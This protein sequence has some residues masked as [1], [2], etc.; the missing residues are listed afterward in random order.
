VHRIEL[1]DRA[2]T[3]RGG[4]AEAAL[5]AMAERFAAQGH[6]LRRPLRALLEELQVPAFLETQ[7]DRHV[8]HLRGA[9]AG[10]AWFP[11]LLAREVAHAALADE[12]HPSHDP[13]LL[14]ASFAA[15]RE[16][17][18]ALP[19]LSLVAAAN[20]HVRDAYADDLAARVAPEE[21]QAFLEHVARAAAVL[22]G[23]DA[24]RAVEC[25][26]TAGT[27]ARRATPAPAE[28]QAALASLPDARRLADAFAGLHPDPEPAD[29]EHALLRLVARLP[30]A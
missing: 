1:Q 4:D 12:G 8:L 26:Y 24:E 2:H 15:A 11:G 20:H 30:G 29:L 21:L 3:G 14:Q 27:L 17:S 23:S 25:G 5:R 22:E 19:F 16:R 28:L 18:K 7:H 10:E 13:A 6:G 9:A